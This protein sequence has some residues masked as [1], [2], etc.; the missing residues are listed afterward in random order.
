MLGPTFLYAAGKVGGPL[1]FEGDVRKEMECLTC[2]GLG[3][4][5]PTDKEKSCPVCYGRGFADYI[6]PGPNRPIQ[7]TGT[8]KDKAGVI[9]KDASIAVSIPGDSASAITLHTNDD[10]QFGFKFP[11]GQYHLSVSAK[12]GGPKLDKDL[13]VDRDERPIPVNGNETLHGLKET[14]ILP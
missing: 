9:V 11:P 12:D 8:V 13:V 5:A 2:H 3:K 14:F 7:L 10:G 4:V 6:I 1:V